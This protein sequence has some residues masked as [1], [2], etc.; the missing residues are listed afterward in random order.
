MAS[1]FGHSIVG[2]TLVKLFKSKQSRWLL[3]LAIA[4][5]ILPDMDVIAFGLNIPYSHP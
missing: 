2:F 5:A 3:I 1:V 4:S